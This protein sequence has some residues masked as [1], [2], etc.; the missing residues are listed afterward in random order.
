M[1]GEYGKW[2]E[3]EAVVFGWHTASEQDCD[4]SEKCKGFPPRLF[5]RPHSRCSPSSATIE[6]EHSHHGEPLRVG[7]LSGGVSVGGP[8]HT[9]R[10]IGHISDIEDVFR[11][12]SLSLCGKYCNLGMSISRDSEMA[13][14]TIPFLDR[15]PCLPNRGRMKFSGDESLIGG[16]T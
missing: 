13:E 10:E 3:L 1:T 7:I 2:I 8:N 9:S 16:Q 12:I 6:S 11:H 15:G 14:L 4:P 5:R